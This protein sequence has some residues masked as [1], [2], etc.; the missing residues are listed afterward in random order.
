MTLGQIYVKS[1]KQAFSSILLGILFSSEK[2]CLRTIHVDAVLA[3]HRVTLVQF[4]VGDV[5][6]RYM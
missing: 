4:R 1:Y 2:S 6:N 5:T 3:L